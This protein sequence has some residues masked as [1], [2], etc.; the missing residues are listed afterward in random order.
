MGIIE[1]IG[2]SLITGAVSSA[3]TIAALKTDINWIKSVQQDQETR[4]R[5]LEGNR[6]GQDRFE[7]K[8]QA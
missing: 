8:R 6:H 3:A 1:A 5:H 7:S 2:I 4:I